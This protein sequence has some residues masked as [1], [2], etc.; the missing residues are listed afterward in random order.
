MPSV[1]CFFCHIVW[2]D[3]SSVATWTNTHLRTPTL[4]IWIKTDSP[5]ALTP[6]PWSLLQQLQQCLPT[7]PDSGRYNTTITTIT[8]AAKWWRFL[9]QWAGAW[10][11]KGLDH[12]SSA[13]A[14]SCLQWR[15]QGCS[16]AGIVQWQACLF[17]QLGGAVVRQRS[18]T[19]MCASP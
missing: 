2:T 18:P 3:S 14:H 8:S 15:R 6:F 4:L 1:A 7:A 13:P 5:D 11:H 16:F 19:L 9:H 10:C 12:F 17:W